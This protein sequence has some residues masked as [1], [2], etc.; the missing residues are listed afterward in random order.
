MKNLFRGYV[1]APLILRI[2]IGLVMWFHIWQQSW[3]SPVFD[4]GIA[5]MVGCKIDF[6]R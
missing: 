4:I 6:G 3:L 2:A 1:K 5:Q